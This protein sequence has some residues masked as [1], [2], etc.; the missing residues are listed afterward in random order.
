MLVSGYFILNSS[1][2]SCLSGILLS[3]SLIIERVDPDDPYNKSALGF[4]FIL[5]SLALSQTGFISAK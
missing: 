2:I 4:L 3:I 1:T 5:R